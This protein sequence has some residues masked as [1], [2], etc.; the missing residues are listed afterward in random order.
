MQVSSTVWGFIFQQDGAPAH[1]AM[2]AQD[3]ITTNCSKFTGKDEW[4]P[5]SPDVNPL[6]YNVCRVML[7]H[8]K[9]FYRKPKNTDGLKKALQLI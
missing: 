5:N 4:L 7:E 2:L 8:Q 1:T 9:T 3:W 6:D